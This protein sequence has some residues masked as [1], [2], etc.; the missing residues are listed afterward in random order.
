MTTSG[1]S[2]RPARKELEKLLLPPAE[3]LYDGQPRQHGGAITD[4]G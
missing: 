1:N 2:F 4:D 3:L